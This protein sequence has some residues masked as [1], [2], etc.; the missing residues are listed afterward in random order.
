[1][2]TKLPPKPYK[3]VQQQLDTYKQ[4]G[5]I[6][7]DNK[8]ALGYLRTIGYYRLSGYAYVFRQVMPDGTVDNAFEP[9]SHF[10]DI[11]ALY[12]F[13]KKLRQLALDA[14]ERIEV[15]MRVRIADRLG[16]F[17]PLAH[18]DEQYFDDKV[19]H[20]DWVARYEAVIAREKHS[21]FVKHH[22]QYYHDI[23]V[24]AG[25]ELWDFGAMSILYKIMRRADKEAIAK[26][27]RLPSAKLLETQLHAFNLIRNISAHHGRLWN[28]HVVFK[29][30]LKGLEPEFRRFDPA[31]VLLY[32]CL[33][34]RML[35]FICPNSTWGQRFLDTL[36]EFPQ[37]SNN[38]VS[39][40]QFGLPKSMSLADLKAWRLWR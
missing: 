34:Q 38:K 22:Q 4:R 23:P 11:K 7:D 36:D 31:K 13:D 6:V 8:K 19:R 9:N 33:M 40:E 32:F 21:D 14:L 24:W 10:Q 35:T 27:Y 25:C 37:M 15:A 18:L 1:M 39:L 3:T 20:A 2:P 30:S 29:A 28:R 16:S 26:Y 17:D 5:L 12:M